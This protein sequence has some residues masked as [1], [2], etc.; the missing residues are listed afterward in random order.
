MLVPFVVVG[1]ILVVA[2]NL[3]LFGGRIHADV[4]FAAAWG[5]VPLLTGYVAQAGRLDAAAVIA[6]AA[7]SRSRMH[8]EA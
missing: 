2:V 7:P 3:E 8:S 4:G 1:P 6:A 5:A